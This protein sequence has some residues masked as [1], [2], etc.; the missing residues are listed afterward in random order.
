MHG[1]AAAAKD[2]PN[3]GKFRDGGTF[4]ALLGVSQRSSQEEI[5]RVFRKLAIR[6]HPDKRGPFESADEEGK[7]N[8][9]FVKVLALRRFYEDAVEAK[10]YS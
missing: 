5:K 7:A 2:T 4:Y 8:D 10:P 6:M 3:N 9:L 1:A